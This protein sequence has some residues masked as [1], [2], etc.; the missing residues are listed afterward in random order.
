MKLAPQPWMDLGGTRKV[1]AALPGA[2]FV[3]GAVRDALLGVV[4]TDVDVATQLPPEAV[5]ERLTAAGV[6]VVPTGIA[7][8][9]VTAVTPEIAI[10]ITTLR[11]DVTTD[12]RRA[13]VAFTDQWQ[14]DAARR[15]FTINALYADPDSGEILDFFGGM[16]DLAARRVRFIGAP[17]ERIAEDHLRILRFFRFH[18]RFGNGAPDADGMAACT[19]RANDLM[20]LSRER[21]RDEI[22]KLLAVTDPEGRITKY[23]Y[24][25]VGRVRFT[26]TNAGA[27]IMRTERRYDAD[28]RLTHQIEARAIGGRKN[29][30]QYTYHDASSP[31]AVCKGR[32]WKV[33]DASQTGL[34]T[35]QPSS[36]T[37]YDA[38]GNV[39]SI[40]D[41]R[42]NT[43]TI[44]YDNL[45][46]EILR[47]YPGTANT[48]GTEY[49]LAG[50]VTRK[51]ANGVEK[52]K[53]T[54]DEFG[55]LTRTDFAGGFASY[56]Y[57]ANGNR[58]MMTDHLGATTYG[59]DGLN[60]LIKITDVW[61]KALEFAYDG[62]GNRTG[63]KY[64]NGQW[65]YYDFDAAERMTTVRP[66]WVTSAAQHTKYTLDK[67]GRVINAAF[68]NGTS[69]VTQYDSAG[70]MILLENKSPNVPGGFVSR[71]ALTLD[72]NGNWANA[73]QVLPLEYA[74]SAT[75]SAALTFDAANRLQTATINGSPWSVSYDTSGR[76]STYREEPHE[77]DGRDLLTKSAGIYNPAS[78]SLYNGAG[79][80]VARTNGAS[81]G[82]A[83][84]HVIDPNPTDPTLWN[85]LVE[86][87]S[88]GVDVYNYVY[89][90]GLL[91]QI[92]AAAQVEYFHFDPTGNTL[93]LTNNS[94]VV[95][96]AFAYSPYG[97]SQ[98]RVASTAP[99]FRY[100]G[101]HGVMT[102]PTTGTVM[103]R[104]RA[105][106]PEIGRFLSLDA[107][108]GD[109]TSPQTVNRYAYGLGDP[110][111]R[112]DPSGYASQT[113]DVQAMLQQAKSYTS[114][115]LRKARDA[116]SE[117]FEK[118]KKIERATFVGTF[119]GM[120]TIYE[121][122]GG[123]RAYTSAESVIPLHYG[124]I[125][126]TMPSWGG[127]VTFTDGSTL[128]LA[129]DTTVSIDVWPQQPSSC[130]A[131]APDSCVDMATAILQNGSL[132]GRILKEPE[133][134]RCN[135]IVA[136]VRG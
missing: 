78:G 32:L 24:D 31:C 3:G 97:E 110:I 85:V 19:A 81:T 91:A 8:G 120:A 107:V 56:T 134:Y 49:N 123:V 75:N 127:T 82:I 136:G 73:S 5:V 122:N 74:Q 59:Y 12:G 55:Q 79:H 17:L 28:G 89:G 125:V 54:Y 114:S 7:H 104:A 23:E 92:Y 18:A 27:T 83:R 69:A 70:R 53:N 99:A 50:Q 111:G 64:P 86:A 117:A 95:T 51:L 103:M 84:K 46:R 48:T 80:R 16:A 71:H 93:A 38:A 52:I 108:N 36:V 128:M 133:Q 43:T 90:Y 15:D 72:D 88:N 41:P 2:K 4:V 62:A 58:T 6:K 109:A 42:G 101:K 106:R 30:T 129:H 130:S 26:E 113:Q 68:G 121:R 116:F 87:D 100:S 20:A 61:G 13:T 126:K 119:V 44:T 65:V 66:W 10:E 135:C 98:S 76:I 67:S 11:R 45:N 57:D 47:T 60:R 33:F 131:D 63:I 21:I 112:V 96:G 105:Y 35:P 34:A 118:Q 77:Y 1:L 25:A 14:E 115:S 94:G 22:S 102:D 29:E 37:L 40:T 39:T 132:W 124:D 9:T